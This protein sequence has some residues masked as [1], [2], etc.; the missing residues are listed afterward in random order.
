MARLDL[1]LTHKCKPEEL[2]AVSEQVAEKSGK[3]WVTTESIRQYNLSHAPDNMN[4]VQKAIRF[5]FVEHPYI[6]FLCFLLIPPV[7]LLPVAMSVPSMS[8]IVLGFGAFIGFVVGSFIF[9][10][11][12]SS[13]KICGAIKKCKQIFSY[14]LDYEEHTEKRY[15][16]GV[17]YKYL[18]REETV[19]CIYECEKCKGRKIELL[20]QTKEK[21]I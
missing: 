19:F 9:P 16:N 15:S 10:N 17:Q 11:L 6:G 1:I 18:V 20:K 5:L 13:C 8:F 4:A 14:C 2:K 3:E 7:L 12:V 21:R